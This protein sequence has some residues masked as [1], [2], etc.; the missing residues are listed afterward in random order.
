MGKKK[1]KAAGV[2]PASNLA[3]L[4]KEQEEAERLALE[5]KERLENEEAE[6]LEKERLEKEK[7]D[8]EQDEDA[9]NPEDLSNEENLEKLKVELKNKQ[10][11][12]DEERSQVAKAIAGLMSEEVVEPKLQGLAAKYG[13]NPPLHILNK[14]S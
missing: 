7:E 8:E 13:V 14:I 2:V 5:E 11:L 1:D 3:Q 10:P 9:T 4:K 12:S 6:R